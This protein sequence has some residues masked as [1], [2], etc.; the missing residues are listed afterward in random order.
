MGKATILLI[1]AVTASVGC[2]GFRSQQQILKGAGNS[3][4]SSSSTA[5]GNTSSDSTSSGA[6]PSTTAPAEPPPQGAAAITTPAEATAPVAPPPS[7]PAFEGVTFT[8]LDYVPSGDL[9]GATYAAYGTFSS[10]YQKTVSN[11]YGIFTSYVRYYVSAG[12]STTGDYGEWTLKRST[13]GGQTFSPIYTVTDSSKAPCVET[14]SAGDI[15]LA[16]STNNW[17]DA[18]YV[19]LSASEGYSVVRSIYLTG[20]GAGKFSCVLQ[21]KSRRFLFLGWSKLV[22]IDTANM[23]IIDSRAFSV[24]GP[25]GYPQY[26]SLTID[27]TDSFITAAWTTVSKINSANYKDIR[28]AVTWD[29]GYSWGVPWIGNNLP[30]PIA[31]DETGG[32]PRV[33]RDADYN[34]AYASES[35]GSQWLNW[36]QN[37]AFISGQFHFM[38]NTYG[39]G[40]TNPGVR[41]VRKNLT[42]PASDVEIERLRGESLEIVG[43][44]SY[45]VLGASGAMYAV[46]SSADSRIVVLRSR[47]AGASWHDFAKSEAQPRAMYA[48][49]G[50]RQTTADGYI[51]G[52]YTEVANSG[53]SY[54]RVRFFKIRAP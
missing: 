53:E 19:K 20:A 1:S 22:R 6:S 37:V 40:V 15:H 42:G 18:W 23:Q 46:G 4:I 43:L 52:A 29:A 38:Y 39:S 24:E 9:G 45:F 27:P 32:A 36:L 35:N 41:Y 11:P 28:Y 26:P 16:W 12:G 14:D 30:L 13:D 49:S 17:T 5:A 21:D 54:P 2:S 10:H 31:V 33:L 48:V 7:A 34:A 8:D 51:I 44:G 3:D 47:D 25:N 50:A